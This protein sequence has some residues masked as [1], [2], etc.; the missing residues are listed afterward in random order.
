MKISIVI[1]AYKEEK[2]ISKVIK[3]VLKEGYNDIIV[4]DDG[5]EDNTSRSALDTG[6]VVLRHVINRGQGAALK[7]GID[8]AVKEGA[9]IIVTFDA[10][11][12]HDAAE[13]EDIIKPVKEGKAEIALGSRFLSKRSKVPFVRKLILKT[14]IIVTWILSGIKLTDTHNGFR[15]FSRKAARKIEIKQ[16]RME[17]ASEIL[18]EIAKKKIK[19]KEVPVT[20]TYS[21]YSKKK[22][23][24]GLNS[25]RI[26]LKMILRKFIR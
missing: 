25:I 20:I 26:G 24:S 21:E 16:D 15:A 11:G 19:Y 2:S 3:D 22:G 1:A 13:I 5:S 8:Y 14:G 23:Q 6:A 12:Q 18:D 17:H 4:V 10:D 9:D 7:T